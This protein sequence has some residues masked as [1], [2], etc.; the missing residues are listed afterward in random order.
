[1]RGRPAPIIKKI[2][3]EIYIPEDLAVRLRLHL[4]S[5]LEG[6]IPVGK[7]SEFFSNLVRD[8]FDKLNSEPPK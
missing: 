1:M 4:Y 6:R 2:R 7:I 8:Y 3:H 5:E